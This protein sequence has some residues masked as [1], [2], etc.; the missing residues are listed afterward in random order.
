MLI[1]TNLL[2]LYGAEEQSFLPLDVIFIEGSTPRYYYQILKGKIKLN[3]YN[4]DGK[5]LILA[6]LTSGLS[7]C[8]LLLFID[9]KYPVNAVVVE[10]CIVLKLL[11]INFERMIDKNHMLSHDINKFLAER[12]YYKYIMLENNLSTHADVRILGVLDYYKSFSADQTQY[13]FEVLLTRLQLAS[14]TGL[15]VETVIRT[16]KKLE[17][18]NK[19]EIRKGKIYI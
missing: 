1:D 10:Q 9:K 4:E 18:Q 3:H 11:K 6:I 14:M 8:E 19:L 5:E 17:K 16:V 7:V 12:L 2:L 15:R 13:S